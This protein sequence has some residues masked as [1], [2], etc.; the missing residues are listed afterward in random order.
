[1]S[2]T[3]SSNLLLKIILKSI[4]TLVTYPALVYNGNTKLGKEYTRVGE[5]PEDTTYFRE[6]LEEATIGINVLQNRTTNM[7]NQLIELK[8]LM[9]NVQNISQEIREL[10]I[11]GEGYRED[12]E[13]LEQRQNNLEGEL[14]NRDKQNLR[15]V[16]TTI[17][18]SISAFLITVGN[19]LIEKILK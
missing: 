19:I 10:K 4:K 3:T 7:E 17:I 9:T 1:M 15:L 12:I 6:K 8:Q 18:T 13:K 5:R 14:A 11:R 2:P 16:I